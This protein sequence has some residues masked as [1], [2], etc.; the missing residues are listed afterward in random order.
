MAGIRL[1]GR[2]PGTPQRDPKAHSQVDIN[3]PNYPHA[4]PF[5]ARY[6]RRDSV[7][8]RLHI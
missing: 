3:A 7:D 5:F 4:G 2:G 6:Q 8:C 1:S